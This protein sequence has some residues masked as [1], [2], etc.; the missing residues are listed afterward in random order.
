MCG[1]VGY[2]GEPIKV[3]KILDTLKLLE[4]RGYDSA[5]IAYIHQNGM[6]EVKKVE[7]KIDKLYDNLEDTSSELIIAHTRWATHGIPNQTNAHPHTSGSLAVVHNGIIENYKEIKEYLK[8]VE[9]KSETDSEV[10]VHLVNHFY[11]DNDLFGAVVKAVDML[12]G[13]FAFVLIDSKTNSLVAVKMESPIVIGI[14][15]HGY[16]VSS[17]IP[18]IIKWTR[19]IV[20]LENGDVFYV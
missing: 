9:F 3:K 7:G 4:Y 11:K 14:L 10:I 19:K 1:I 8:D 12:R 16:I 15:D 2:K 18:S 17:D 13:A 5:G 20:N 6:L